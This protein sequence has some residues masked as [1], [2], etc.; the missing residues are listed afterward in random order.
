MSSETLKR[1]VKLKPGKNSLDND[2]DKF[3]V[4]FIEYSPLLFEGCQCFILVFFSLFSTLIIILFSLYIGTVE[5]Y[6]YD[7][8]LNRIVDKSGAGL[9]VNACYLSVT[10]VCAVNGF[11][12]PIQIEQF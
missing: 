4:P 12:K 3:K 8:Y 1:T 5:K 6:A 11:L 10:S 2:I 9:E 7:N